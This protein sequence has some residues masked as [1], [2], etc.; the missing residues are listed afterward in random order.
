MNSM[1]RGIVTLLKSAV[2]GEALPLPEDFVLEDA[3]RL[4]QG[5]A[6]FPLIYQG[7]YQCG[8]PKD[9]PIMQRYQSKAFS[10]LMFNDKQMRLLKQIFQAFE[11]NGI[12]YMP[13]KGCNLKLLYP[14]SAMRIMSDADVLIRVDQYDR[15]RP[16]I[17]GLG[18]EEGDDYSHVRDWKHKDLYLELHKTL[19]PNLEKDF[20]PYFGNGWSKAVLQEGHRYA[21]PHEEEF[22]FLFTHM[23]KHYRG[24]GIGVRQF[25][26]LYVYRRKY[27]DMD[28]GYIESAMEQLHL[29]E[30]YRN[31]CR[32]LDVWFEDGP[33]DPVTDYMTHF[34][35]TNGDWGDEQTQILSNQV[36][37]NGGGGQIRN[38]KW[39]AF[40]RGVFL[41]MDIM[42]LR[43]PVLVKHPW[44]YPLCCVVRWF[45][46]LFRPKLVQKRMQEVNSVTDQKISARK[47]SLNMVGLDFYDE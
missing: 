32:L 11:E 5:Q 46:L 35:M 8:I 7:G 20:Y 25:L 40:W 9:H 1:Y 18:F 16:I 37:Q 19:V 14:Q 43:Y 22:V 13:L 39:R 4:I 23:T 30:F 29:L 10:A 15:I 47:R 42:R 17:A 24:G 34:I 28:E 27:P 33:S 41:S 2:T 12:D 26:D 45:R 31:T 21:L 44:M 3:V 6:L 38:S 36:R